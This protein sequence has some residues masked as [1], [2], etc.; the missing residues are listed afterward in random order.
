MCY[1]DNGDNAKHERMMWQT[2]WTGS[3][4]VAKLEFLADERSAEAVP[5]ATQE[6]AGILPRL[7]HKH[8]P[9]NLFQFYYSQIIPQSTLCNL[10]N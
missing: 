1:E 5:Q 7:R 10:V 8:F 4:E 9:P 3:W 6:S 2:V